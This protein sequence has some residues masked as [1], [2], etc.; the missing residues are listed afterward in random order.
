MTDWTNPEK[1]SKEKKTGEVK[2]TT[3]IINFTG[4]VNFFILLYNKKYKNL[5][6]YNLNTK[7]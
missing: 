4:R 5:I 3:R 7:E 2:L 1:K 6:Y